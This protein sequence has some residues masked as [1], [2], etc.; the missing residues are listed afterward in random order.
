[1]RKAHGTPPTAVTGAGVETGYRLYLWA[2]HKWGQNKW[3]QWATDSGP[4]SVGDR[5][6]PWT[7]SAHLPPSLLCSSC[8]PSI[9]PLLSR[10]VCLF[11]SFSTAES[12]HL[13]VL[14]THLT[15]AQRGVCSPAP[16]A[17]PS[18]QTTVPELCSRVHLALRSTPTRQRRVP[19]FE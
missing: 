12:N 10:L 15:C 1:M 8:Y 19:S 3:H 6:A 2:E 14:K 11:L 17:A 18:V 7:V 5:Q 4:V 9:L 16:A 13:N